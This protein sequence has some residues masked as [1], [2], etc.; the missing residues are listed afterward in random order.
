MVP[1][2]TVDDHTMFSVY[3]HVKFRKSVF[4]VIKSLI[5]KTT[6]SGVEDF[7]NDLALQ[8]S[9]HFCSPPVRHK[10]HHRSKFIAFG[11]M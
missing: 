4:S 6:Y 7:H 3:L 8:L 2:R 11:R 9:R 5:E 10:R 1:S